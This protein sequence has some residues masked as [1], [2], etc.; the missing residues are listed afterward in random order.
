MKS[1]RSHLSFVNRW[2][3]VKPSTY[4]RAH[5]HSLLGWDVPG[6]AVAL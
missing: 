4:A 6:C 5:V 2:V 1:A 3:K